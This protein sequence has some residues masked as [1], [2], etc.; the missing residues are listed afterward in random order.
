MKSFSLAE[1]YRGRQILITGATGFLGKVLLTMVLDRFPEIGKVYVLV[2]KKRPQS[3]KQRFEVMA[4]YSHAFRTLHEAFETE[5]SDYLSRRVEVLEG[6]VSLPNLGLDAKTATRVQQNLDLL[7]NSAG[8]VDFDP[9][10]RDALST[11]VDGGLN[12]LEFVRRSPKARLLHISTCYVAG[13]RSGAIHETLTPNYC[14]SG[15]PFDAEAEYIEIQQRIATLTKSLDNDIEMNEIRA[16]VVKKMT[17]RGTDTSDYNLFNHFVQREKKKT[18]KRKLI[19]MARSRANEL[20]W[21][22]IYTYSKS[23]SE[24]LLVSRAGDVPFA[25][26]RP[27]IVE[28]SRSFPFPGWNEGFNTSGPIVAVL[29]SWWRHCPCD[30]TAA[31]DL[32]PVDTVCN[33]MLIAGAALLRGEQKPVYQMATSSINPISMERSVELCT[34]THRRELRKQGKTLTDRLVRS[35]F[36]AITTEGGLFYDAKNLQAMVGTVAGWLDKLPAT[37]PDEWK[38]RADKLRQLTTVA[39]RQLGMVKKIFDTFK[40][41]VELN[42]PV[43][44]MQN[45]E[46]HLI[47]EHEEFSVDVRFDWRDY[48]MN[49]HQPGLVKWCLPVLQGKSAEIYRPKTPVVLRAPEAVE[50]HETT[51]ARKYA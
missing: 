3:A 22:N 14:P 20:G 7:I 43:F 48:W 21:P 26:L 30:P 51:L 4:S 9:D 15:K 6:D 40:P 50:T 45:I 33:G 42:K 5:L 12:V 23:L 25:V 19:A 44:L 11:N 29:G 2:R 8:L 16:N 39:D 10:P 17:E 24:S 36:D 13:N 18:L 38:K 47:A 1:Q 31:L 27:A 41:F 34:L 46:S 28:S 49:V 35:R 32:I 37:L